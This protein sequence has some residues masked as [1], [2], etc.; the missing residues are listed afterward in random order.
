MLLGA[1]IGA[2]VLAMAAYGFWM[3]GE[4]GVAARWESSRRRR[5]SPSPIDPPEEP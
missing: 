3:A 4:L 1:I 2:V 5:T